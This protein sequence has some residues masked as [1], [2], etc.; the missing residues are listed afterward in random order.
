VYYPETKLER[1]QGENRAI[2]RYL[3]STCAPTT[4]VKKS[5]P[6]RFCLLCYNKRKQDYPDDQTDSKALKGI[7]ITGGFHESTIF[8]NPELNPEII[9]HAASNLSLYWKS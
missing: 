7:N 3:F 5:P 8:W 1:A 4:Q 6:P 9:S 2:Q